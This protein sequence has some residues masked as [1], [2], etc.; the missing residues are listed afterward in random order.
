MFS[1]HLIHL[2]WK[3]VSTARKLKNLSP[4][5]WR[6][7]TVKYKTDYHVT[8]AIAF[9]NGRTHLHLYCFAANWDSPVIC[10]NIHLHLIRA[11]CFHTKDWFNCLVK[12]FN[13]LWVDPTEQ[14]PCVDLVEALHA[15]NIC[16]YVSFSNVYQYA[17]GMQSIRSRSSVVWQRFVNIWF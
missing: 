15:I 9:I 2:T 1:L 17:I 6:S 10:H 11:N 13:H 8:R 16:H 3:F 5:P 4:N 12:F 14:I 7:T